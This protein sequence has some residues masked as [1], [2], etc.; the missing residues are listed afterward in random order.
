MS[1]RDVEKIATIHGAMNRRPPAVQHH[2]DSNPQTVA[3]RSE[4]IRRRE[5]RWSA[6]IRRARA[7][8]V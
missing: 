4:A 2:P 8:T 6:P 5:P 3:S 7:G 1:P